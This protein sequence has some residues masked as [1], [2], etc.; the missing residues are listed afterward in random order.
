MQRFVVRVKNGG[1]MFRAITLIIWAAI[2]AVGVFA[3]AQVCQVPDDMKPEQKLPCV[4]AGSM[5]LE[6]PVLTPAQL[7]NGPDFN[8]SQPETS[9]FAYFTEADNINCYFMPHYAFQRVKGDSMKF[10]CW[11]M[12]PDGAFF[13]Q[14]GQTVRLDAAKVVVEAKK[15]GNKSASLYAANDTGNE[16]KIKADHFKVK[17]LKPPYPNHNT[18]FNEVFT[19]VAATRIMWV[20]GFPTDHVYPAASAACVGCTADPFGSNLSENKASLKD[21]PNIFKIVNAEREAPWDKISVNDD[22][23]WS[24]GDA[25]KFY[26]DGEWTKDQ[27]VQYDAYRLALGL[28]HYHNAIPQQNRLSCAEWDPGT[29]GSAKVCRRPVIYVHDLGSTFGKAKGGLDLFGTNPR[30]S[31]KAWAPQTVFINA[32]TCE[33]RATQGGDKKVLKEAQE[34]MI[35]RLARLDQQTVRAIFRQARFHMMDQEQLRRLRKGGA[36]DLDAA[37]LDEWTGTFLKRIEEVRTA[38]NCKAN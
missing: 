9:R 21:A 24:W 5:M 3:Q 29:S 23:T 2:S 4:R 30:G 22:E 37:A 31:F 38:K 16:H 11:H 8:P 26:S 20:L 18:R 33:L 25:A 19:S 6:Q 14:N 17:Y 27:R 28:I 7:S 36:Q 1:H 15:S 34:L 12:T 32:D 13:L 10:Q 35:Q